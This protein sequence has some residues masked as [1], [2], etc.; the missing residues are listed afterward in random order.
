MIRKIQVTQAKVPAIL[1]SLSLVKIA[2]DVANIEYTQYLDHNLRSPTIH[3]KLNTA[4]ANL[5]YAG[6]QIAS[7]FLTVPNEDVTEGIT[8]K[9]HEIM[10]LIMKLDEPTVDELLGNLQ[11]VTTEAQS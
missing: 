5:E 6:K 1:R 3:A 8:F 11:K 9:L 4:S 10:Q 7:A 2:T